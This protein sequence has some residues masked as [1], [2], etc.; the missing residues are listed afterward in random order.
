VSKVCYKNKPRCLP[1]AEINTCRKKRIFLHQLYFLLYIYFT[2]PTMALMEHRSNPNLH[3]RKYPRIQKYWNATTL[4]ICLQ[5]SADQCQWISDQL[6][7]RAAYNTAHQQHQ[8]MRFR[9][10]ALPRDVMSLQSL[11]QSD[12]AVTFS[13]AEDISVSVTRVEYSHIPR[14]VIHIAIESIHHHQ[15]THTPV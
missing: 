15:H 10:H 2:E 5:P 12:V 14:L 8:S 9:F 6:P 3:T 11:Q 7:T 13:A 1:K 4:T